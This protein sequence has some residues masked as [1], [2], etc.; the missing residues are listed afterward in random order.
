M[1]VQGTIHSRANTGALLKTIFD[2]D[3]QETVQNET[4]FLKYARQKNFPLDGSAFTI[5]VHV[6]RNG[7]VQYTNVGDDLP[8]SGQ[9]GFVNGTI[10]ASR[11]FAA[12]QI[13]NELI[14][15]ADRDE[16]TFSERVEAVYDDV[17]QALLKDG[18]RVVLG[19]GSGVLAT[20][21]AN[22]TGGSA[23]ATATVSTAPGSGGGVEDTRFLEEGMLFN[24]WGTN[25]SRLATCAGPNTE[26]TVKWG[27]IQTINPDGVTFT[28]A[29][30][31]GSNVP[32]GIVANDVIT[33]A[34]NCNLT[35]SVRTSKEANGMA[36]ICD[37]NS[38]FMGID[39]TTATGLRRWRGTVLDATAGSGV[40]VPFGAGMIAQA[41]VKSRQATAMKDHP[42]VCYTHP[43][44]TFALV[45]GAAGTFPDIRY[46]REDVNKFGQSSKPVFNID[47]KDVVLETCLDMIK[48]KMYLFKADAL[49]YGEL[50]AP[51]LE[52]FGDISILPAV[53][54]ATNGIVAA[55]KGWFSWRFNLGC[56]R[57]NAFTQITGLSV[58]AGL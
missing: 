32:A 8:D 37:N 57:R 5:A 29:M 31:D 41:I 50:Q 22:V 56:L 40:A 25:T 43:A 12:F 27:V 34:K 58:P 9:A 17:K 52:D 18:E 51:G 10:V 54:T 14:K 49:L 42:N 47:G 35:S 1:A 21:G 38:S 39:G 44:Q 3:L 6:K 55:Q 45:Y 33:R 15:L 16:A 24:I 2:D 19:D 26:E 48:S 13:D 46:T 7:S 23:T 20:I 11:V 53:N 36:L 28:F 4:P 30:T